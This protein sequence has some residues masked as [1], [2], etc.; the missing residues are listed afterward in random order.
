LVD[1]SNYPVSIT[2]YAAGFYLSY[3]D[4]KQKEKNGVDM[5]LFTQMYQEYLNGNAA[6]ALLKLIEVKVQRYGWF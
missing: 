5:P 3:Y 1:T 4:G 2:E 6:K